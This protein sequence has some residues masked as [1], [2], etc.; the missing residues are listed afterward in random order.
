MKRR[1]PA[2]LARM[3]AAACALAAQYILGSEQ[4]DWEGDHL[5]CHTLQSPSLVCPHVSS[6]VRTRSESYAEICDLEATPCV[7]QDILRLDV[8]V[9]YAPA[10]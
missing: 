3:Y 10:V 7:D 1:M 8:S 5:R 9:Y 6:N 2:W 4:Q